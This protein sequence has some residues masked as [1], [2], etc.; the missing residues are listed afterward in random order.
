MA[1]TRP[2]AGG[3][4]SSKRYCQ[5]PGEAGHRQPGETGRSSGR[6]SDGRQRS[7]ATRV[8]GSSRLSR[9]SPLPSYSTAPCEGY[10][11]LGAAPARTPATPPAKEPRPPVGQPHLVGQHLG[12]LVVADREHLLDDLGERRALDLGEGVALGAGPVR[13]GLADHVMPARRS[14]AAK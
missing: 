2:R 12:G 14:F 1:R 10:A 6:S 13:P 11:E 3:A 4:P 9:E 7:T 5:R 8:A